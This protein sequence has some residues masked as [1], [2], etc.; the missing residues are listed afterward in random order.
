MVADPANM[1]LELEYFC[2]E[3]NE[4]WDLSDDRAVALANQE[5]SKIRIIDAADVLAPTVLWTDKTGLWEFNT[6][7]D[8]REEKGRST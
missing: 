1:C 3:S 2:N 6:E 4:I 7:L 5:L 8:Y